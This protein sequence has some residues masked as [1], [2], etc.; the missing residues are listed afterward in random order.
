MN[1]NLLF[2]RFRPCAFECAVGHIEKKIPQ[3]RR[4]LNVPARG[5][6]FNQFPIGITVRILPELDCGIGAFH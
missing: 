4:G 3:A 2:S 1:A 6:T 5:Y